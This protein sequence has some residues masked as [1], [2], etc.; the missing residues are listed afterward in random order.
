MLHDEQRLPSFRSRLGAYFRDSISSW[1]G[2][3]GWILVLA[4]P[5]NWALTVL[6]D[7][8]ILSNYG[9]SIGRFLNTG[10]GTAAIVM[11]G[12]S[13]IGLA[14]YNREKAIL[15]SRA[16]QAVS[17]STAVRS[18][19]HITIQTGTGTDYD[20]RTP[21]Q[22]GIVHL[23]RAKVSNTSGNIA[24]DARLSIVNLNP[25]SAGSRDFFLRD[26]TLPDGEDRYIDLASHIEGVESARNLMRL[27]ILY[28]AGFYAPD[29]FG[30]LSGEHRFQ[31]RLTQNEKIRAEIYCR[32]Y[33]DDSNVMRL[34][35]LDGPL[36]SFT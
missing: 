23:I 31:L 6:G 19:G 15:S 7:I 33:V 1:S 22:G 16:Q 3:A 9:G 30:I 12:A 26:I 4:R 18:E 36:N 14:I 8:D 24:A 5:A 13:I 21:S 20:L 27:Q 11:I 25:Q 17:P 28:P 29:N 32:L 34:E 10:V 2:F 35:R